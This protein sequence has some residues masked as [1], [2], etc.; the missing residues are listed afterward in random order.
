MLAHER[1]DSNP[2]LCT[3]QAGCP[4]TCGAGGSCFSCPST[5]Q[6]S[7]LAGSKD[8]VNDSPTIN[9][10][11]CDGRCQTPYPTAGGVAYVDVWGTSQTIN[12]YHRESRPLFVT[13]TRPMVYH[14]ALAAHCAMRLRPSNPLRSS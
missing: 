8:D 7:T 11:D 1:A 6:I 13:R 5:V 14:R 12:P 10:F 3:R 4:S 2:A 9:G